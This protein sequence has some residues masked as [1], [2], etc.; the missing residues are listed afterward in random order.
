MHF[1]GKSTQQNRFKIFRVCQLTLSQKSFFSLNMGFPH[2]FQPTNL[3]FAI[4]PG[5]LS[6]CLSSMT[7]VFPAPGGATSNDPEAEAGWAGCAS[8]KG[9]LDSLGVSKNSGFSPQIIHFNRVFHYKPSILGYHYFWKHPYSEATGGWF[10]TSHGWFRN[11]SQKFGGGWVF[12]F[13]RSL[14]EISEHAKASQ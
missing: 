7:V 1:T 2:R 5:E 8:W 9:R 3:V 14:L 4:F 10:L 11:K 12:C 6:D 13:V